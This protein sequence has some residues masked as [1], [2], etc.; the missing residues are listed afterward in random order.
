MANSSPLS[1]VLDFLRGWPTYVPLTAR[2]K[3]ASSITGDILG[4][5]VCHLNNSGEFE[6][7]A[8]G[9][10][11]PIFIFHPSNSDAVAQV[12]DTEDGAVGS[13]PE[14]TLFGLIGIG[15]YELQSTEFQS[16]VTF[17]YN[18]LLTSPTVGQ[19]ANLSGGAT[20]DEAGMLYKTR[21]WNEGDGAAVTTADN[22]CAVVSQP[23]STNGHGRQVLSFWT[24]YLPI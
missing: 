1:H 17:N 2:G 24:V 16:G 19:D 4:G 9:T 21:S 13:P 23:V 20:E 12:Y 8:T 11:V 15:P 10:Q 3:K 14:G 7:G 6:L 5:R 22:V 18:D